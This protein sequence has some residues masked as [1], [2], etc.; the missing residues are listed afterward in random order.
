[1]NKNIKPCK[2]IVTFSSSKCLCEYCGKHFA[3]GEQFEKHKGCFLPNINEEPDQVMGE[4][5]FDENNIPQ[6]NASERT[7]ITD[8]VD[9][10]GSYQC[11]DCTIM[12]TTR[13]AFRKHHKNAHKKDDNTKLGVIQK[14]SPGN[15]CDKSFVKNADFEIHKKHKHL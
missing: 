12:F 7:I 14:S 1:M 4:S 6:L 9:K 8:S 2:A 11:K 5:M 3:T 15:E 13:T 10:E